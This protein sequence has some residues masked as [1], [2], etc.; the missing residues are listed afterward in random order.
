MP[1]ISA[2][3]NF[4]STKNAEEWVVQERK[5]VIHSKVLYSDGYDVSEAPEEPSYLSVQIGDADHH[6]KVEVYDTENG[7]ED[8]ISSL[9]A[10]GLNPS[11]D[12]YGSLYTNLI[13]YDKPVP[14]PSPVSDKAQKVLDELDDL[15]DAELKRVYGVIGALVRNRTAPKCPCGRQLQGRFKEL[16]VCLSCKKESEKAKKEAEKK[17][18]AGAK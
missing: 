8:Y 4:M 15:S 14:V 17:G 5:V 2:I 7:Y 1:D 9:Q 3:D 10:L 12:V 13:E 18:D 11:A 6:F 16:G